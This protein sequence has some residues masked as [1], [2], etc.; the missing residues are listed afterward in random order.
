[1]D[2]DPEMD[3][4]LKRIGT[5]RR[6][7]LA[8]AVA[9]TTAAAT[10]LARA[11][12]ISVTPAQIEFGTLKPHEVKK[13]DVVIKNTGKDV[14][15][16]HDVEVTCGCTVA[17]LT[18]KELNPGES[19]ILAVNF[20]S[21]EFRGPQTKHI[22][23]FSN[24]PVYASYDLVLTANIKVP[25]YWDSDVR[26]IGF[27]ITRAGKT[28]S[29]VWNFWTEDVPALVMKVDSKPEWVDIAI[30][31]GFGGDKKK[32]QVTFTLRAD[33]PPGRHRGTINLTTNVPNEPTFTA[34]TATVVTLD[35]LL[36]TDRVAFNYVQPGQKL[37]TRVRVSPA[38]KGT[39]FKLT[40]AEIDIPG[41]KARIENTIAGEEGQAVIEGNALPKDD[42]TLIKAN[43]R[44]K[45]TLKIYSDLPSTPVMEVE[46]T[47]MVRL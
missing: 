27:E 1:M 11:Q 45:G 8:L 18:K 21:K 5:M 37:L 9:V 31:N 42:P 15:K 36:G 4:E 24:D 12:T 10:D 40:K 2:R 46:V 26:S 30:V 16:I 34:E 47:Y 38:E 14:L 7:C 17:E 20:D 43:G 23:I 39:R 25:L 35:L 33:T 32:S 28:N 6:L 44:M 41:L 3:R 13:T 29:K 22:T 19:T